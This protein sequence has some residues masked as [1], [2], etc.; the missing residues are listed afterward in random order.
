MKPNFKVKMNNV[1]RNISK[2]SPLIMTTLGI[3]TSVSAVATAFKVAPR[4][5]QILDEI[6]ANKSTD[7]SKGK[8][9]WEKTKA[10]APL[11][12]P[13]IV[14]E[15][16][17]VGCIA[18][19]YK[20][21][22]KRLAALG[23]AYS[24][25]E[26]RFDEYREHV[27]KNLGEKKEQRIHDDIAADKIKE[28]QEKLTVAQVP[29]GKVLCLDSVTERVF[30]SD[31][32]TLKRIENKLNKRL[33]DEMFIS[34]ND[35]YYEIDDPNLRPCR[36]GE[37]LGWNSDKLIDICFSSHLLEDGRPC[38]VID[39]TTAPRADYRKLY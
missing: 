5:K 4:A 38:M 24:L 34:L 22:S 36:A 26:R 2:N 11:V 39:Y 20:V 14:Q 9:F 6:D 12:G 31:M 17:A 7:D 1:R 28:N 37:E 25:S 30:Y 3:V 10:V 19:S 35:F 18:G 23:M 33:I 16:V 27:I 8:I 13:V 29:E 21:N 15:A 32:E